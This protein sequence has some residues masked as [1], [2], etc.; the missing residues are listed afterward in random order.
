[1]TKST[2]NG[3]REWSKHVLLE[4]ETCGKFREDVT[5]EITKLQVEI[6]QLKVKA[7]IWGAIG[8]SV[9]FAAWYFVTKKN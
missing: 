9:A 4:I 7:G 3:W 8:A 5:K 6:A 2:R 1:M